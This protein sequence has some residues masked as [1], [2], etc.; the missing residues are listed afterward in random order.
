MKNNDNF[1]IFLGCSIA[2][3][4]LAACLFTVGFPSIFTTLQNDEQ[5]I[6]FEALPVA[7]ISNIPTKKAI[8]E[9]LE[10]PVDARNVQASKTPAIAPEP[11]PAEKIPEPKKEK[12]ET[13]TEKKQEEPKAKKEPEPQQKEKAKDKKKQN[14][15]DLE[16]LLKNLEKSSK[17][18]NN[19]SNKRNNSNGDNEA[20]S[21]GS[22]N[23]DMPLSISEKALIK[24]QI[25][26][27]W[28]IPI[29]TQGID[30]I[31]I[32]VYI[33]LNKD[34]SVAEV[35]VTD[36]MC[37][38]IPSAVCEL[39]VDSCTRAVWQSSPIQNLPEPRYNTWKAF[40]FLFD[41][42]DMTR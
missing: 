33:A 7:A 37:T 38:G 21:K 13:I 40:N 1:L 11:K 23:E 20:E 29:G 5:I 14:T 28:Q 30:Q 27:N 4:L 39:F 8:K 10:E 15:S 6:T 31:K 9:K 25:E 42:T 26:K 22:F 41:P 36:K 3:H 16:S 12:V 17:G 32:V 18:N 34:G 24:Q 2:I 19:K 35:K